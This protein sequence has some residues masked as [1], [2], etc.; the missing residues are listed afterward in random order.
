MIIVIREVQSEYIN[1]TV[2]DWKKTEHFRGA[3]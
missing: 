1:F 2:T 3:L